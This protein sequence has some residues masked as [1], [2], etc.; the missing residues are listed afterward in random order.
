MPTPPIPPPN[1][2]MSGFTTKSKPKVQMGA[3]VSMRTKASLLLYAE[4]IRVSI[5]DLIAKLLN[6]EAKRLE[7]PVITK[8]PNPNSFNLGFT[9]TTTYILKNSD[10]NVRVLIEEGKLLSEKVSKKRINQ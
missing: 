1:P 9:E 7:A 3:R 4:K 10:I 2:K 5:S 8:T 6:D